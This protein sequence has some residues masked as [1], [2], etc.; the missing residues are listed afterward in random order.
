ML[1][2]DYYYILMACNVSR[3]DTK[4]KKTM[5]HENKFNF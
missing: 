2:N 5:K 3:V 1:W 4:I